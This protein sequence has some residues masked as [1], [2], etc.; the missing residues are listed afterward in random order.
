MRFRQIT[1]TP[2]RNNSPRADKTDSP[3][4]QASPRNRKYNTASLSAV[5][6]CTGAPPQAGNKMFSAFQ[7]QHLIQVLYSVPDYHLKQRVINAFDDLRYN[8]DNL[9]LHPPW[10]SAA[11]LTA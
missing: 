10:P 11:A 2:V 8:A 4:K 1:A 9:A 3:G 5:F 6:S 7:M